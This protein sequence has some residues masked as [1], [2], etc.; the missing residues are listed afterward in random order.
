LDTPPIRRFPD[1][2]PAPLADAWF[3]RLQNRDWR[4]YSIQMFGRKVQEPRL[5]DWCGDRPYIY[6]RR[7]LEPR[8]VDADV[9][10]LMKQVS[11]QAGVEF[12]HCLMNLYRDGADS[13]GW[14]RDDEPELGPNPTIA[15]L[16]L[17]A[18]RDFQMRGPDES[19]ANLTLQHGE[20]LIMDPPCQRD[21]RH[22]LPKRAR[23]NM[24]INLTFRRIIST[25]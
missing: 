24:R 6:S 3:E 5:I 22:Q 13:M 4:Q 7:I 18:A 14:H 25:P 20:L 9:L 16:S 19:R 21:W 12:N 15:S 23:A 1:F 10:G 11:H 8:P 2:L 17:G